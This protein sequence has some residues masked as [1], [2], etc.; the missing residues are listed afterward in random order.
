MLLIPRL[1]LS[2]IVVEGAEDA[3][4]KLGPGHIRGTSFPG[5]SG[6]IGIAAHRDT[7]FRPLRYVRKD[8]TIEVT[9]Q[10]REYSYKVVS[11]A[12]VSPDEV[13]VLYPQGRETLTLVT[14]YP[15]NF[16]GAAPKRFVV[17][18]DCMNCP[19]LK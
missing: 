2:S 11:T 1:G 8:D 13:R 19:T 15:F 16:V 10:T 17:Q 7:F 14:C 3:Q 4:L 5:E 18:A 9:T 12:V 6:N